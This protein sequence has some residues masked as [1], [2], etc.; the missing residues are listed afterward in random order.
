MKRL[1]F[2]LITSLIFT[3]CGLIGDLL[4]YEGDQEERA[5]DYDPNDDWDDFD[6]NDH[7]GGRTTRARPILAARKAQMTPLSSWVAIVG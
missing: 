2:F 3:G 7:Y 6:P 4:E 5:E 1:A